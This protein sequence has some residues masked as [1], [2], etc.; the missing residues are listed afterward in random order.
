MKFKSKAHLAQE[1]IAGKRFTNNGKFVIYYDPT[2]TNPFRCNTHKMES[3]W[4]LYDKDIWTE[5]ECKPR[6]IHQELMDSYQEGQAW[7][8]KCGDVFKNNVDGNGNWVKPTWEESIIYRL[9]PHNELIQAHRNGAKIQA[10]ICGD[11]VEEPYPDWYDDTKY[12][13]KPETKKVY[14]WMFKCKLG[15]SWVIA[16]RIM[17]EEEAKKY[18]VKCEYRKSGREFEVEE[19]ST[20]NQ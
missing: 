5:I 19:E 11:W 6:H 18:F 4:E 1:L 3:I 14:E 20:N 7:Q 15:G 10:Y 2:H 12:R 9:H 17:D 16:D 8:V 13:I